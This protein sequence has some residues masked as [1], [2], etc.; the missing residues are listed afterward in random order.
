M[1]LRQAVMRVICVW[2]SLGRGIALPLPSCSSRASQPVALRATSAILSRAPF[3]ACRASELW[4]I[5][6][7]PTAHSR[8]L[9]T[10][11]LQVLLLRKERM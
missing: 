10:T 6:K 3:M 5:S 1:S 11:R 8:T 4:Q 7:T 2:H 9:S